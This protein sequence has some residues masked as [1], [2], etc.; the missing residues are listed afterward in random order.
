MPKLKIYDLAP[1]EMKEEFARLRPQGMDLRNL[2]SKNI[3][4]NQNANLGLNRLI[5]M[6]EFTTY[7]YT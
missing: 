4:E 6:Y 5:E 3:N 1:T 7:F 2:L